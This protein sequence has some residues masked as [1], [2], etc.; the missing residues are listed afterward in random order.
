MKVIIISILLIMSLGFLNCNFDNGDK[1]NNDPGENNSRDPIVDPIWSEWIKDN[2]FSIDSVTDESSF[3]DIQFLK[4]IIQNRRLVQLGE[5]SHG[6][7]E[8]NQI[9]VRLIKFLHEE[10]G[11][12]VIAFESGIFECYYGNQYIESQ[13]PESLM[14][15]S[16]FGV[17]QTNEVIKL[18]D[19][20]INTQKTENPLILAGFDTQFSGAFRASRPT[21][22]KDLIAPINNEYAEEVFQ[23]DTNLVNYFPKNSYDDFKE[24]VKQNR[25]FL[26]LFYLTIID[27]IDNN[28]DK[29]VD[30]NGGDLTSVLIARQ[31]VLST[32]KFLNQIIVVPLEGGLIR[33]EGM[34]DNLSFL[35]ETVYPDKKIITW[36]HNGHILHANP[37]V[38]KYQGYNKRSMG[39]WI[40]ERYR[41]SLYTIALYMYEGQAAQNDRKIY[42]ITRPLDNSLEAICNEAAGEFIFVDMLNQV[43]VEGNSW[44]FAMTPVRSWGIYEQ[45]MVP[46]D[47]YDAI[48][49]IKTV[50]PP[51]YY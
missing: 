21:F 16:I 43:E 26:E 41:S 9:K 10:M 4:S 27:F 2:S 42:N 50:H 20:I 46:R 30:K 35:I 13:T 48:L 23:E 29:I 8:F 33:D 38:Q 32:I 6:V 47:Q 17:W 44:M 12:N 37:K 40:S 19:Y 36:A 39:S 24:Y 1:V 15:G 49:F 51:D 22:L 7:M 45:K 3:E 28:I 14:K 31:S 5:S 34:A 11:F 25:E 18:F